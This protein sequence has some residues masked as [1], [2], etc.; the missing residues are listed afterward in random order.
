MSRNVLLSV[1]LVAAMGLLGGC[2]SIDFL[3]PFSPDKVDLQPLFAELVPNQTW[4][5][6]TA[7]HLSL[8]AASGCLCRSLLIRQPVVVRT[9]TRTSAARLCQV[10]CAGRSRECARPPQ[11]NVERDRAP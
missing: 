8:P 1:M 4:T 5:V 11:S 2:D 9:A 6:G 7:V 3:N 10:L